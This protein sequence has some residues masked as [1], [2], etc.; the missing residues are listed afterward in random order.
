MLLDVCY[1]AQKSKS[2]PTQ[3]RQVAW[4]DHRVTDKRKDLA[5]R[6]VQLSGEWKE[7]R[8]AKEEDKR[9]EALNNRTFEVV[10]SS[11][12]DSSDCEIDNLEPIPSTSK[13]KSGRKKAGHAAR[14]RG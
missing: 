4:H 7:K 12:C 5:A 1:Q 6:I 9:K 13:A 14:L 11:D 10:E 3:E 8:T 2:I